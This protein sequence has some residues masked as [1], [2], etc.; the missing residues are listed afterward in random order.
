MRR[1]IF[2]M[3]IILVFGLTVLGQNEWSK[4]IEKI[5]PLKSSEQD[6]EKILGK[7]TKRYVD[8]GEYE[9]KDGFFTVTYSQGRCKSTIT[10]KY[11]IPE[12]VVIKF[13]FSPRKKYILSSLG[14][15][16]LDFTVTGTSD[17]PGAKEYSNVNK[18]RNYSFFKDE[19]NYV[20]VYPSEDLDY[21]I[22]SKNSG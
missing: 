11:D 14:L 4:K 6:V 10:P 13:D 9:T 7:P 19:L 18:G 22:C 5:K 3:L 16:L 17:V 20:E 15:N 1:K 8:V 21:L 12:G 2:L